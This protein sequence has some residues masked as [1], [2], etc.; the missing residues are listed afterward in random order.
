M[1]ENKGKTPNPLKF[2]QSTE[3]EI[4]GISQIGCSKLKITKQGSK[5]EEENVPGSEGEGR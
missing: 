2:L 5:Q 3:I 1:K 4:E